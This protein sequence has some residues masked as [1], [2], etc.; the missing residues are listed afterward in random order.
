[1]TSMPWLATAGGEG[2]LQQRP[3][4]DGR[5][6]PTTKVAGGEHAP[7]ARPRAKNELGVE[8]GV[9]ATLRMPSVPN[10]RPTP[11]HRFEY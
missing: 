2:G 7:L 4:T 9:L 6:R 10:R 8:F 5:S 11:D 3:S 1:M